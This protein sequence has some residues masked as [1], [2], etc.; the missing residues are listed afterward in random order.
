VEGCSELNS[1]LII[2]GKT[3]R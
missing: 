2:L 3:P 1:D